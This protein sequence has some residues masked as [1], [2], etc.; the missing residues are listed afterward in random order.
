MNASRQDAWTED[1]DIVLAETVIRY[2]REGKTQLEAFKDVARQL[3]RTSAA[4]GFRWN[5]TIRKHYQHAIQLA[6]DER[7]QQN[8]KDIYQ[9]KILEGN[10]KETIQTAISLLEQMKLS[11]SEEGKDRILR[12]DQDKQVADLKIENEKLKKKILRYEHAW[13]EMGK[14]WT[15]V[16]AES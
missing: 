6:K 3:S 16:N 1:E 15:W 2:I 10:S 13:E 8:R 4:C 7:K 14:L 9:D 12:E 11:L 5:A